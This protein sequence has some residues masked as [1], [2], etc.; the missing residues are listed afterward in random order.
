MKVWAPPTKAE[1]P[2]RNVCIDEYLDDYCNPLD[3]SDLPDL[4]MEHVTTSILTS[5]N[6]SPGPDG[7][8]FVAYRTTIDDSARV[9]LAYGRHLREHPKDLRSFNTATLL[10]L[11]KSSSNLVKDTRPLCVNN[12]DN[13]LIAHALVILITPTVD[14]LL[15]D[16]QQG[17][18]RGRQM[19]RHLFELNQE[20][21]SKWSA[22]EDFFVLLT[23]NAKAFDSI[24]HDFIL[25]V[26]AKQRFPPWFL[27]TVLSLLSSIV[28][29]STLAPSSV[30]PIKRGVKQGCP[31]S[32]TLFV[33]IYDPLVRALKRVEAL[34][35]RAAADDLAVASSSVELLVTDAIPRIDEFCS[36]SGM[37]INRTKSVILS[38]CA[39]DDPPLH[40]SLC[41][42]PVLSHNSPQTSP[43]IISHIPLAPPQ[44][45]DNFGIVEDLAPGG[46]E[47]EQPSG[48][49]FD[50][51]PEDPVLAHTLHRPTSC[52]TPP[53]SPCVA[54]DSYT[55]SR[56]AEDLA[57][58]G[59]EEES[60]SLLSRPPDPPVNPAPG[61]NRNPHEMQLRTRSTAVAPTLR[62]RSKPRVKPA[63]VSVKPKASQAA[64]LKTKR[65]KGPRL[66]QPK[67][68]AVPEIPVESIVDKRW[69]PNQ[70]PSNKI[71][72]DRS[73]PFG[74]W[75]Y[76]VHWGGYGPDHDT[77]EPLVNLSCSLETVADFDALWERPRTFPRSTWVERDKVS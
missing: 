10:L 4:S 40:P 25:K 74:F 30:I 54:H 46:S 42:P 67:K 23:D 60:L 29:S 18:V 3:A 76:L 66:T 63:R 64:G 59:G 52:L 77:W 75:E 45:E 57:P 61:K 50:S 9:L 34:K 33:L 19:T 32:P 1:Q 47:E 58:L 70:H 27:A 69:N 56:I 26:L 31:L 35:P 36:A 68:H 71:D 38:A 12:T 62:Q 24:H 2:T 21:Y 14:Q 37:G 28:V 17:F 49:V 51:D 13:R 43:H 53:V 8:P 11:P 7:I 72:P 55:P 73:D 48:Q 16:A 65:K 5:G 6:T 15:D 39:L 22:N 44:F 20:F 41:S